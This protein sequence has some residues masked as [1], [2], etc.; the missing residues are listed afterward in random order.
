MEP[1]P[2][3]MRPATW[4]ITTSITFARSSMLRYITSPTLPIAITLA[5]PPSI[6]WSTR[7]RMLASSNSP[8][9]VKGVTGRQFAPSSIL[10]SV[11]P[12]YWHLS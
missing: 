12:C 6:T 11:P 1:N 3:G 8:D 2:T 10:I 5:T 7:R 4:S 9:S